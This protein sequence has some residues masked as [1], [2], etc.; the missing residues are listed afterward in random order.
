[1]HSSATVSAASVELSSTTMFKFA[2]QN[3]RPIC[4][5]RYQS[6]VWAAKRTNRFKT[7]TDTSPNVDGRA[8][9]YTRK[10][11][12]ITLIFIKIKRMKPAIPCASHCHCAREK[13]KSTDRTEYLCKSNQSTV[14]R[15]SWAEKH[16]SAE[17]ALSL[18]LWQCYNFVQPSRKLNIFH[19]LIETETKY[20]TQW[21]PSNT[22]Q[23]LLQKRFA[24]EHDRVRTT[25]Q[26][27]TALTSLTCSRTLMVRGPKRTCPL[28]RMW[29]SWQLIAV[30]QLRQVARNWKTF[31]TVK[32]IGSI[33]QTRY[34]SSCWQSIKSIKYETLAS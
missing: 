30:W 3:W 33:L 17:G 8:N 18:G 24:N 26:V 19:F 34:C 27:R 23:G 10:F 1:M 2:T 22:P 7:L 11:S 15:A 21:D 16:L 32:A 5:P 25:P 14:W 31:N 9:G 4:V 29:S 28:W 6:I 13:Q 20:P 12:I